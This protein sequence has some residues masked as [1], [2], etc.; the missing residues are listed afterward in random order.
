MEALLA[1]MPENSP[2]QL[3]V[4]VLVCG[5]ILNSSEPTSALLAHVMDAINKVLVQDQRK[6]VSHSGS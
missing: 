2:S 1:P 5:V 4:R 6:M 3:Y